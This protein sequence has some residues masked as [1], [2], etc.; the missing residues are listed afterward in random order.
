M[1]GLKRGTLTVVP[2]DPEWRKFFAKERKRILNTIGQYIVTLEHVGSTAVQDMCAKP[3]ID[4]AVG[5]KKFTDGFKCV[6]GLTTIGYMYRGEFGIPGRHYFRTDSKIVTCHI[7]MHEIASE[8]WENYI[9]FRDYLRTHKKEAGEYA[10]LKKDLLR[11]YSS[12]R[13]KYTEAKAGFINEI[14]QKARAI[15]DNT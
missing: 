13:E 7:H 9:L 15:H 12:D 1:V 4:I 14:L 3:I 6:K 10:V 2:Y 11:K 5:L 8:R